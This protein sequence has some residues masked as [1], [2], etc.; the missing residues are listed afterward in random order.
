MISPGI[1]STG[2]PPLG[3]PLVGDDV[4]VREGGGRHATTTAAKITAV[5]RVWVTIEAANSRRQW[6]LRK[7]TQRDARGVGY[8]TNFVTPE[9][10]A[11]DEKAS[12]AA[13]YL[14]EQG[15]RV[16]YDSPWRGSDGTIA[17][18]EILR[19]ATAGGGR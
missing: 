2:R 11:Y 8:A 1:S 4:F 17:L 12:T 5:G 19:Q 3:V 16:E 7:D 10:L 14:A 18:A 6:K 15:I 9:Q 13:K